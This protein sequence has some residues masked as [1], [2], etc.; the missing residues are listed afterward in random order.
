[1]LSQMSRK[2]RSYLSLG[3][4]VLV[5]SSLAQYPVSAGEGSTKFYNFVLEVRIW[6]VS[7]NL[8]LGQK[9]G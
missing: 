7:R 6:V 5:F 1:M 4:T 8:G 3:E 2:E 9:F